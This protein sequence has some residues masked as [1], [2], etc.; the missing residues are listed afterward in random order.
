MIPKK[1]ESL[2]HPF[3][4]SCV[5]LREKKR[6]RDEKQEILL[7]GKKLCCEAPHIRTLILLEGTPPP[8][9]APETIEVTE[10]ILK[11]IT[12]VPTPEPIAAIAPMPPPSKLTG[13]LLLALDG[14]SDPG[15]VGTLI[16]TALALDFDGVLF[17]NACA[18]PFN[19]KVLRAAKGATFHLPYQLGGFEKLL[20]NRASYVADRRGTPTNEITFKSPSILVVGSE[21]HG[22]SPE[23]L[24]QCARVAIPISSTVDSLNVAVA[25]GIVMERMRWQK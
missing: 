11:K 3:V 7:V 18:D 16:R 10:G 19:E 6:F 12:G 20:E 8:R 2:K 14:V 21:S 23:I 15:N 22:P 24:T 5:N 25:G 1:I 17:L 13:N 4:I 9:E